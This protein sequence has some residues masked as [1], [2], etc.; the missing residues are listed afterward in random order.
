M[1]WIITPLSIVFHKFNVFCQAFSP[2]RAIKS[3]SVFN[4]MFAT[5][6]VKITIT[7]TI[8]FATWQ[9]K[10]YIPLQEAQTFIT[11]Y[12]SSYYSNLFIILVFL[13]FLALFK[14]E[15]LK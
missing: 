12:H 15:H 2:D 5:A 9:G 6:D 10:L 11:I 3:V 8:F 13:N 14:Q 4:V 1:C 7:N